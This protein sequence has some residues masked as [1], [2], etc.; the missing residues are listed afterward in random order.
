MTLI[1]QDQRETNKIIKAIGKNTYLTNEIKDE[2][3]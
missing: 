1:E 2:Y 3:K